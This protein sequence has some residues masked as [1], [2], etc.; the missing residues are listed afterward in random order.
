MRVRKTKRRDWQVWYATMSDI[1]FQLIVFFALAGK[2]TKSTT[3]EV[4]LPP[5]DLGERTA[6]REIEVVVTKDARY[7]VNG[8]RVEPEGLREEIESYITPDT[9]DEE[10]TVILHADRDAE[11][12]AVVTAI[13]AI[14]QA[15]AYLEL[16][17][18]H[19]Q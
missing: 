1:A 16:A 13:E 2:F 14:N 4:V 7:L 3:K 9:G 6:V 11:Y 10:R 5:V 12:G 17:V 19:T 18:T 15:D 8:N